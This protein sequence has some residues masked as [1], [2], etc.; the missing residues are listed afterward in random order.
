M[1]RKKLGIV[2][3]MGS[4]AA[5][6]FFKRLVELTPARAD[7][8]HIET[9]VHNNPAVPDRTQGLLY[10]GAS[11]LPELRRSVAILNDAGADYIVLACMTAHVFIPDLQP[12]SRAAI[13]DGIEETAR[14]IARHHG[15]VRRVGLLATTGTIRVGLFQRRLEEI[16]VAAVLL[17]PEEQ[18]RLFMESV[19]KEWG[20]KAGHCDGEPRERMLRAVSLLTAAGAQAVIGGCTEVPLVLRRP[21]MAVPLLDPID[22]LLGSA[23]SFC[24]AGEGRADSGGGRAQ[25]GVED[26]PAAARAGRDDRHE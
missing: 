15:A 23:I 5:A 17:P 13:L 4:A 24:L 6:Y 1:A 11:P 22:I 20:I 8:E 7:Q 16:G 12:G 26:S 21:D 3:G 9:F 18:E 25:D 2:G 10:G 19:Y 14:H